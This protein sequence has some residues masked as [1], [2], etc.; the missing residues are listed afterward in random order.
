MFTI[1]NPLVNEPD[2]SF[3]SD[4]GLQ[5]GVKVSRK[6][7]EFELN[8]SGFPMNDIAALNGAKSVQ[9]YQILLQKIQ[10]Y[11]AENPDTSS[12]TVEQLINTV[13]PR[14]AQ[15]PAEIVQAAEFI[16]SRMNEDYQQKVVAIRTAKLK[17]VER[18][19]QQQQTSTVEYS[20]PS[21]TPATN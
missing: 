1:S 12:L 11:Q 21:I 8:D 20:E 6:V 19:Q 13:Q 18:Q 9:E 2:F 5:V 16:G 7:E 17:A 14:F 3:K 15:T 10:M 4:D